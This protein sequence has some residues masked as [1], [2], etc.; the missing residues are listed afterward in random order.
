MSIK[1]SQDDG[2][3]MFECLTHLSETCV[4]ND[5]GSLTLGTSEIKM[6]EDAIAHAMFP[7]LTSAMDYDL[8]DGQTCPK[9]NEHFYEFPALSRRDNETEI[10]PTCGT[11][12]ALD[13]IVGAGVTIK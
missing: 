4:K 13:D 10:C 8:R 7:V 9:C 1:F 2:V 5:D 12:E 11:L 6:I 3:K